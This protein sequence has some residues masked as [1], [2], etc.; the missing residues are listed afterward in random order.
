M[1]HLLTLILISFSIC[2]IG[3]SL[4][5]AFNQSG[6]TPTINAHTKSLN[7]YNLSSYDLGVN[8]GTQQSAAISLYP[9][10][11]NSNTTSFITDSTIQSTSFTADGTL[12]GISYTNTTPFNYFLHTFQLTPYFFKLQSNHFDTSE[13][14]FVMHPPTMQSITITDIAVWDND[15]LKKVHL[16]TPLS[17]TGTIQTLI[18]QK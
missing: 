9:G 11:Y 18:T 16:S 10:Y 12:T 14:K 8:D 13:V 2:S 15:T 7:I 4:Q 17:V 6:V 3:Q 5:H 1:K